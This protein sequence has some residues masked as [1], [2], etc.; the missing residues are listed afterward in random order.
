MTRTIMKRTMF[1]AI[2]TLEK[3]FSDG[4]VYFAVNGNRTGKTF[5]NAKSAF[6]WVKSNIFEES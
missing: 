2:F 4:T 6:E 5:S 1:G 3:D